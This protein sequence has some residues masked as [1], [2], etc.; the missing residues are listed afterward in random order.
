MT[1]SY[2]PRSRVAVCPSKDRLSDLVRSRA[3]LRATDEFKRALV[4]P[5]RNMPHGAKADCP[6]LVSLLKHID[7]GDNRVA[8]TMM[9]LVFSAKALDRSRESCRH[10]FD[11]GASI[12]NAQF[13][14][15]EPASF[16]DLTELE[17]ELQGAIDV[18]QVQMLRKTVSSQGKL[19]ALENLRR[20]RKLIDRMISWLEKDLFGGRS[21]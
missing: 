19:N 10:V 15:D 12:V 8:E 14:I 11:V 4:A 1:V 2:V 20:M 18:F 3:Y 6:K 16:E 5:F 21:Q 13:P 7:S 9:T 17:T